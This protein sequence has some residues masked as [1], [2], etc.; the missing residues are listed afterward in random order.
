MGRSEAVIV[1]DT[2]CLTPF[3]FT[4]WLAARPLFVI[5]PVNVASAPVKVPVSFIGPATVMLDI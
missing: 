4:N 1:E 3:V 2:S 5:V